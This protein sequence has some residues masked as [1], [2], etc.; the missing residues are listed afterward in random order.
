M[1]EPKV[2]LKPEV[3]YSI[4]REGAVFRFTEPSVDQINLTVRKMSKT[5]VTAAKEFCAALI[6]KPDSE[7]WAAAVAAKPGYA[8]VAMT[9]ILD[10]L[11]F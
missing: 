4:E 8:S 5:P 2:S 9:E 1:S 10:Q 7:A 6:F 11:G 3:F